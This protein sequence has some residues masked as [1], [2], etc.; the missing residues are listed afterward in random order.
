M[1]KLVITTAVFQLSSGCMAALDDDPQPAPRQRSGSTHTA[2]RRTFY[3]QASGD[4]TRSGQSPAQSWRSLA[5]V[6]AEVLA[7]GDRVLFEGG[8]RFEGTLALDSE[9][10]GTADDP[11]TIGSFGAGRA[12]LAAGDGDGISITNAEGFVIERLRIAGDWDAQQQRGNDGRGVHA[13]GTES[14]R[15]FHFL[16]L[17]ELEVR[18]FKWAGIGLY[19]QPSDERKQSGFAD[20]ELSHCS[21]HDNG[22]VGVISD[23][24]FTYD[25]GYSHADVR[26]REL[27]VYDNRGLTSKGSHT[28]SGIVLADVE[29]ALVE[30]TI[31]HDN[32]EYND[33]AQG[34]GFG[35]WAWDATRVV[36]QYNEAY[37]N[38]SQTADGGGFDLD[39]GVTDSVLQYN[40]SH[41]NDGA[42]LGL[43]QFT[44]A[45]PFANNRAHYNISQN[46]GAGVLLWDGNGDMGAVTVAHNVVF[47]SA[48][49]LTTYS[50]IPDALLIDNVFD[51][52][53]D[54]LLDVF[55]GA[56]LT[57][58][59]NAY[60][61]GDAPL[62]ITWNAGSDPHTFDN[63]GAYRDAT[64]QERFDGKDTGVYGDPGLVAPGTAGTLDDSQLLS[65]LTMYQLRDDSPLIDRAIDPAQ[66]QADLPT[67]DFFGAGTPRGERRDIGI[68]ESR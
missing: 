44:S 32:G 14:G 65:S 3:V 64:A 46:D 21:V 18:G 51:C 31:A 34:G 6:N 33:A 35:I 26:V 24:P 55:A 40:Y 41:D 10:S 66:F 36:I 30:H 68:D 11:V 59:G 50:E 27:R 13:I 62:R 45:R 38:R 49:C 47:G 19:A 63:F 1:R 37:H 42:G 12:T 22:D 9:D 25:R 60:W 54:K 2:Q 53:G 43:F 52:H 17:R 15:R 57:L 61:S 48:P 28:G 7:P 23:G 8:A 29:D 16:R 58:Q 4:D 67:R 39:G 5:R 20:V 56:G